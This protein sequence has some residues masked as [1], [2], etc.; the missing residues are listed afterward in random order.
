MCGQCLGL[1]LIK[2]ISNFI[3]RDVTCVQCNGEGLVGDPKSDG[4]A[5]MARG[6]YARAVELY[7]QSQSLT[8][9]ANRT[10]ALLRLE[11]FSAAVQD[12]TR[13]IDQGDETLR[14]KG[15]LRRGLALAAMHDPTALDD[16]DAVLQM[17][18]GHP[19]ALA[20][21]AKVADLSSCD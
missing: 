21:R 8:A 11:Q 13:V 9:L 14:I 3:V 7:A 16:F 4:D 6:D 10:L 20:E 1:G 5:C 19:R 2:E 17:Q 18:P 12:A 15:L